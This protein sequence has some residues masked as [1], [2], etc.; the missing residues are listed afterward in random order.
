MQ[1][2]EELQQLIKMKAHLS[3]GGSGPTAGLKPWDKEFCRREAKVSLCV[4]YW[5]MY[6]LWWNLGTSFCHAGLQQDIDALLESARGHFHI[7]GI[8][9]GL[10]QILQRTFGVTVAQQ[11]LAPGGPYLG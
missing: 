2:E 3:H 6:A 8:L 4:T 11:T 9:T 10:Q 7:R 5:M 1:M